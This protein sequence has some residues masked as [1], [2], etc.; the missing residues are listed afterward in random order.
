MDE[1]LDY[2]ARMA[3]Y[4]KT[5]LADSVI[6]VYRL[7]SLAHGGFSKIYGD[8]DVGILLNCT[9]PPVAIPGLIAEAKALDAEYGNKLSI[10]WGNPDFN[11]GR[12]PVI[13][14]LDLLDHGVPLLCGV[15]PNFR[16]PTRDEIH[17]EQLQSIERSWK[18]R[19]PELSRLT[20]L[21]A[22]DRKPN[23]RAIL[24]A[25][26]LVYTWDNLA[27]DSN[28]R[29]VEYLHQVQPPGLDLKPID[30][31]LACRNE[32]CTAEDVFALRCDLERQCERAVS[33]ISANGQ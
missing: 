20:A 13:D 25:A 31:A 21:E 24:Y 28:D 19:L 3:G 12:L 10:F 8:I 5:A 9:E 11:W 1:L 23:I 15:K 4:F 14:R 27:V 29:A 32:K 16:R 18:S 6:E 33:Y 22:K 17:Q 30:M 7:G 2:V 26:R